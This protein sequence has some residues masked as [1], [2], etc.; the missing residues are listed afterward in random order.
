MIYTL[1]LT[2][3]SQA[4]LR[5]IK[6]QQLLDA[7]GKVLGREI[8]TIN[9][10]IDAEDD[11]NHELLTVYITRE[12][13][14]HRFFSFI[15]PE[16][17]RQIIAYLRERVNNRNEKLHPQVTDGI[18]RKFNGDPITPYALREVVIRAGELAGFKTSQEGAY[19]WWRGHALRKYFISTIKNK[20]GDT[21]LAEWLV[22]HKPDNTSS[23]YWYKDPEDLQKRY[24]QALEF[25]SI[26]GG[27]VLSFESRE[28]RDVMK[29][30]GGVKWVLE[31]LD[32]DP[33][34]QNDA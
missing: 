1:A 30:L 19:A 9:D 27:R 31:L 2:G 6:I 3:L 23:T 15:P 28:Y 22:G 10:F 21:E 18:F 8:R 32:E 5:N 25:L 29:H 11:L 24:L 4:E 33:E 26:D 17:L 16:A 13:V 34:F 20:L 14:H 7:A 12:K